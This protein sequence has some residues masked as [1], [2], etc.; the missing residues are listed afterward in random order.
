MFLP[1]A[2]LAG[3]ARRT[4]QAFT[5]LADVPVEQLEEPATF[6][7]GEFK[8]SYADEELAIRSPADWTDDGFWFG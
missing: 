1:N 3:A 6:S 7:I 4:S 5:R 8:V 2:S